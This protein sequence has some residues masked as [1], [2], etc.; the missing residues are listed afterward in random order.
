MFCLSSLSSLWSI[1]DEHKG[2]F[3]YFV[4]TKLSLSFILFC[5]ERSMRTIQWQRVIMKCLCPA[6]SK[7]DTITAWVCWVAEGH[8]IEGKVRLL[9][10]AQIFF[11]LL[12][13]SMQDISPSTLMS[14]RKME[15]CIVNF[16]NRFFFCVCVHDAKIFE[17]KCL[18]AFCCKVGIFPACKLQSWSWIP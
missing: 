1:F 3:C 7:L 11:S 16:T 12:W 17:S 10:L 15:N 8:S 9:T 18:V 6:K 13:D 2:I 4:Q 14:S 5:L